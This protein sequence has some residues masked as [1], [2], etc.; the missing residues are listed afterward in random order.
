MKQELLEHFRQALEQEKRRNVQLL[1]QIDDGVLNTSLADSLEELSAYDQHPADIATEVFERTKEVSLR[2]DVQIRLNAIDHALTCLDKGNYGQ[3]DIC[4]RDIPVA[5][6][7]ALPYTTQCVDCHS[8]YAEALSRGPARPPE[9]DVLEPLLTG[10]T[11]QQ[12]I[13]YDPEDA[14][15]DLAQWQEH[16]PHSGAGSYYGGDSGDEEAVGY[17]E[18]VDHIPYEVGE[19]GMFY[20]ETGGGEGYCS[21]FFDPQTPDTQNR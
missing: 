1:R 18:L 13:M 7:E 15:Q 4:G 11:G 3:C 20:E 5:R 10:S 14:W 17:T 2:R 19:D 8:H 12:E 9:E 16:S 21:I 6:L